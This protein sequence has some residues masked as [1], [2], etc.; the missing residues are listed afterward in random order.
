MI[1]HSAL[2][3]H[4]SL[5]V[6]GIDPGTTVTGYGVV[7]QE[8]QRLSLVTAG[9]IRGGS[10]LGLAERLSRIHAGL[11]KI[12]R[13]YGPQEAAVEE[14]FYAKNVRSAVMLGHGRGVALL[15][16]AEAG[17]PVYEYPATII[18]KAV[19]GYGQASKHQVRTMVERL[20]GA[21]PGL[22]L[23]TS[24]ALAVAICHLHHGGRS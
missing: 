2:I 7:A 21:A 14:V 13:D 22:G 4:H 3:I 24:D 8:G 16:A 5:V 19:V 17:L 9:Q 18:K 11:A 23:D 10:S 15:A 12:I 6:L 20:L 1:H